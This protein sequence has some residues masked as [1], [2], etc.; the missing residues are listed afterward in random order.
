MRAWFTKV[1]CY[2]IAALNPGTTPQQLRLIAQTLEDFDFSKDRDVSVWKT[3]LKDVV[4]PPLK[5]VLYVVA[6]PLLLV[7]GM[8]FFA[9]WMMYGLTD[10]IVKEYRD[11]KDRR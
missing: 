3:K 11:W 8:V 5:I 9:G 4:W 7:G 2:M 1:L 10:E 6:A